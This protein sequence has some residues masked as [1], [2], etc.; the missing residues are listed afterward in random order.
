LQDTTL[1]DIHTGSTREIAFRAIKMGISIATIVSI[2]IT[3][4]FLPMMVYN[5][6]L[7][8]QTHNRIMYSK[9]AQSLSLIELFFTIIMATWG[10]KS[11][12]DELERKTWQ[13]VTPTTA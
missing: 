6:F 9:V 3:I 12:L 13:P 1:F 2:L 7:I 4:F 5:I 8:W 10:T 11:V